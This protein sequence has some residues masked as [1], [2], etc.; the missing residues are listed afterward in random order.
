MDSRIIIKRESSFYYWSKKYK[1]EIDDVVI[2]ELANGE[3]IESNISI[4]SH[5]ICFIPV[6]VFAKCEKT[7]NVNITESAT[8]FEIY[9]T[10][11]KLNGKII[12]KENNPGDKSIIEEYKNDNQSNNGA[13][14][15]LKGDN[16]QLYV[17]ENKIEITRKGIFALAFQGLKGTKTIPISEIKSIQVKRAGLMVG[18]IQFGLGGG[19]EGQHGVKEAN[20][21]ENTVTFYRADNEYVQEIKEFIESV[22]LNKGKMN[23]PTRPNSNA[24][25][26]RKYAELLKEGIISKEEFDA[27]KK[28]LLGI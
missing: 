3:T 19:I 15:T 7:V 8:T 1:V 14:Y 24:E 9:A 23:N 18:Y 17:Y 10:L 16:G 27:K 21:D 2:G 26:L 11:D 28:Q 4:G 25:E 13:V 6:G 12:L 22:M 20:Y 5:K